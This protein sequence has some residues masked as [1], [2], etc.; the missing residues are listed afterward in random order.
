MD[1]IIRKPAFCSI[2]VLYSCVLRCK[3]CYMWKNARMRDELSIEEWKGFIRSLKKFTATDCS[4]NITGGE[5]LLKKEV[6]QLA[7]FAVEEGFRNISMTTNGF[8]VDRGIAGKLIDSGL[9]M[10]SFS[11]DSL[12]AKVHDDIRGVR[13]SSKRV[14]DAIGYLSCRR[15][16]L[17]KIGIQ[18]IIMGPNLDTIIDLAKW[19]GRKNI[20]VYFMAVVKPLC[21]TLP[22]TWQTDHELGYL[23][24]KDKE[25][26]YRVLD[27]L[28]KLKKGGADIGNS[29]AQLEV[30][31][32]YFSSPHEFIKK[33]RRCKMGDGMLKIGPSGEAALCAEKGPIGNVREGDIED[34]WNSERAGIVR[35]EISSCRSNCPQL[36]NCYFEE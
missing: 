21:L 29:A 25:R 14:M 12:D 22:D 30:F 1:K 31:K 4:V 20:S 23:W 32:T 28:I 10:V 15:G 27:E 17:V 3:M 8:L 7:E 2:E 33:S 18:T 26:L 11:L 9:S 13:G 24:P 35:E 34:I 16:R 19:A 5:P 36:I 6:L